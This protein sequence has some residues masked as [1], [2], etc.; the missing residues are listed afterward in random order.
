MADKTP[1]TESDLDEIKKVANKMIITVA[2]AEGFEPMCVTRGQVRYV[3]LAGQKWH[4]KRC[5]TE[6]EPQEDQVGP[7]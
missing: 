4:E 5:E 3:L 1:L 6:R 7:R 2:Q